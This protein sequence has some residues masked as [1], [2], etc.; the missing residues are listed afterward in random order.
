MPKC[1]R[2][3]AIGLSAAAVVALASSAR[4]VTAQAP[5]PIHTVFV[6]V[7]ENTS[8]SAIASWIFPERE[9]PESE[10]P[11][12]REPAGREPASR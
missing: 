3:I 2:T 5:A 8:W 4:R 11:I 12:D 1:L 9:A 6:I 7:F 10:Q